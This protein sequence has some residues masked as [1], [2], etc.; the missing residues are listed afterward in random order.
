[1]AP[2][3]RVPHTLRHVEMTPDD[4]ANV[5]LTDDVVIARHALLPGANDFWLYC[6]EFE[7]GE[8]VRQPV[9]NLKTVAILRTSRGME[10]L[11]KFLRPEAIVARDVRGVWVIILWVD[12]PEPRLQVP[13]PMFA[14]PHVAAAA[15]RA[16][17]HALVK[18]KLVEVEDRAARRQTVEGQQLELAKGQTRL[19]RIFRRRDRLVDAGGPMPG[20]AEGASR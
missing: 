20:R 19:R 1:M 9:T 14:Q 2:K 8:S 11:R 17:T 13:L 4:L 5:E 18:K 3:Q 7:T 6:F 10:F 16:L 15:Q 12:C